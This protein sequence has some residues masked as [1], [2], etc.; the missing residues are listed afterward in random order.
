MN[1]NVHVYTHTL[2]TGQSLVNK[3]QQHVGWMN[4][5]QKKSPLKCHFYQICIYFVINLTELVLSLKK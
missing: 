4:R 1:L 3:K 5:K 2:L